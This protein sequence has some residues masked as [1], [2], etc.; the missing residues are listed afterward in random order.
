MKRPVEYEPLRDIFVTG[1]SIEEPAPGVF[2][3]VLSTRHEGE[4]RAAASLVMS[5]RDLVDMNQKVASYLLAHG[6]A[7][8]DRSR[9]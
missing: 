6:L 1:V 2:R 7:L 5:E 8:P 9:S 3:A 4:E